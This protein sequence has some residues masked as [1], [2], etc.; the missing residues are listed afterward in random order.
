M[1]AESVR[2]ASHCHQTPQVGRPQ[3][4][5]VTSMSAV[6]TTPTS[7]ADDAKR[8]HTRERV[9][10]ISHSTLATAITPKAR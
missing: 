6:N 9:A 8:S 4:E 7:A 5:P 2:R 1:S 10:G 3:I